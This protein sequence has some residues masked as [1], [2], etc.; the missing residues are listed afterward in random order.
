M[1][2]GVRFDVKLKVGEDSLFM[3]RISRQ[4]KGIRKTEPTACYYVCER[5]DSAS[6]KKVGRIEEL[7]RIAYL[8]LV[9]SGMLFKG[10][11]VLF[12]ASRMAA[13]LIHLRR[14]L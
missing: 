10:Y 8:V 7:K 12:I 9:Y 11:N 3:A 5:V 1:V 6:R 14:L 13:S 2:G 4:V